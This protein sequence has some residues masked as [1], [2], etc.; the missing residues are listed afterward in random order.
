MVLQITRDVAEPI[1][2][3]DFVDKPQCGPQCRDAGTAARNTKIDNPQAEEA[4][5]QQN[6]AFW[7]RLSRCA[8]DALRLKK[9]PR[10]AMLAYGRLSRSLNMWPLTILL[11]SVTMREGVASSETVS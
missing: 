9:F 8:L 7:Y 4:E 6:N 2:Y 10:D 1:A 11:P 3:I 5:E